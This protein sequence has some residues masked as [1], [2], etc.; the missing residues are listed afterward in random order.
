MAALWDRQCERYLWFAES[1]EESALCRDVTRGKPLN[2]PRL[3]QQPKRAYP[4][5]ATAGVFVGRVLWID[6]SESR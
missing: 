4:V 1:D 2:N 5:S 3:P 6:E